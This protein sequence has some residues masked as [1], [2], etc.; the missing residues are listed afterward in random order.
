[1]VFKKDAIQTIISR[2]IKKYLQVVVVGVD[3]PETAMFNNATTKDVM[4]LQYNAN[5]KYGLLG[6]VDRELKG[7]KFRHTEFPGLRVPSAALALNANL[8]MTQSPQKGNI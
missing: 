5:D 2:Y 7:L 4:E 6:I 8:S 1:M 3:I